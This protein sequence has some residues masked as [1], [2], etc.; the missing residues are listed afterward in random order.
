LCIAPYETAEHCGV[1]DN[2]C[3]GN[4][5]LCAPVDDNFEC[6]DACEDPLVACADQCVDILTHPLHCGRCFNVC[7]S[8]VCVDGMCLGDTAGHIVYT[9]MSYEQV[10]EQ[11]AQTRL[12]GNAV[13]LLNRDPVRVLAYSEHA[14]AGVMNAVDRAIAWA[15][16]RINRDAQITRENDVSEIED[17]LVR[18]DYEV[19]LV[20]DQA[21]AGAGELAA[22]GGQLATVLDDFTI[23]G[24]VV[25]VLSSGTGTMG[26]FA[27]SAGLA[28][29]GVETDHTFELVYNQANGDAIGLGV[30]TP[31]I[32]LLE[33]CTFDT[34]ETQSANTVFVATDT[35]P[36][37]GLG[38]PV[39][40]HK[41][42]TP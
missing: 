30:V 1:C 3:A 36:V 42:I 33:S 40:L 24:G 23:A 10:F 22:A 26:E 2:E 9:C 4:T 6:V 14:A 25:L 16:N 18:S 39:V 15:G 27:T 11:S 8:G 34:T 20:Y 19:L 21:G 41:I 17:T 29:V 32:S 5:P 28:N 13:Y 12:L 37:D 38:R 31:F 35:N 7:P